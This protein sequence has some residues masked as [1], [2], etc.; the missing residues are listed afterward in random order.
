MRAVSMGHE[1]AF[2]RAVVS[3]P[4]ICIYLLFLASFLYFFLSS[5]S[6]GTSFQSDNLLMTTKFEVFFATA[7]QDLTRL[8]GLFNNFA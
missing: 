2:C 6:A 5:A 3:F 4:L 7:R 1:S 8:L